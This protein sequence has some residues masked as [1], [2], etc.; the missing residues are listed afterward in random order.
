M[1][2]ASANETF[3]YSSLPLSFGSFAS[4]A[5]TIRVGLRSPSTEYP[6]IPLSVSDIRPLSLLQ[7][8]A[9]FALIS[10]GLA[11]VCVY[12]I[13]LGWYQWAVLSCCPV[14]IYRRKA[15]GPP[16]PY[17]RRAFKLALLFVTIVI[18]GSCVFNFAGSTHVMLAGRD[19]QATVLDLIGYLRTAVR[20]IPRA[21]DTVFISM[22]DGMRNG[23]VERLVSAS[24]TAS[25]AGSVSPDLNA[26][27]SGLTPVSSA[28]AAVAANATVAASHQAA[29][30]S[31]MALVQSQLASVVSMMSAMAG[32]MAIPSANGR[33]YALR[34]TRQFP[35]T[36][37]PGNASLASARL[38]AVPSISAAFALF[39]N[40]SSV[41]AYLSQSQS[42]T[43]NV[44]RTV[45]QLVSTVFTGYFDGCGDTVTRTK[46]DIVT[47]VLVYLI[48]AEETLDGYGRRMTAWFESVDTA[49]IYRHFFQGLVSTVVVGFFVVWW[50]EVPLHSARMIRSLAVPAT[51]V[52]AMVSIVTILSM[53]ATAFLGDTCNMAF[54]VKPPVLAKNLNVPII[55]DNIDN[56]IFLRDQCQSGQMLLDIGVR[57]GVVTADQVN[58]TAKILGRIPAFAAPPAMNM[59]ASLPLA[60]PPASFFASVTSF[61]S[62]ATLDTATLADLT[63]NVIPAIRSDLASVRSF[64]SSMASSGTTS[65]FL[66]SSGTT[67]A[68]KNRALADF[69]ARCNALVGVID[70]LSATAGPLD[71]LGSETDR[72]VLDLNGLA[73][74]TVNLQAR[75]AS[76]LVSYSGATATLRTYGSQ[77]A[78]NTTEYVRSRAME[79]ATAA[80]LAM[81]NSLKCTNLGSQTYLVQDQICGMFLSAADVVWLSFMIIAVFGALAIPLLMHGTRSLFFSRLDDERTF[82]YWRARPADYARLVAQ[83]GG[84][85]PTD[86]EAA[87]YVQRQRQSSYDPSLRGGVLPSS[88]ASGKSKLS[89]MT[90][91]NTLQ[92]PEHATLQM[93]VMDTPLSPSLPPI[94]EDRYGNLAPLPMP[95]SIIRSTQPYLQRQQSSSSYHSA[96]S[97]F[98]APSIHLIP[99]QQR[100]QHPQ[101]G[102]ESLASGTSYSSSVPSS[103]AERSTLSEPPEQHQG[104]R[105]YDYATYDDMRETNRRFAGS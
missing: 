33:L 27:V 98:H 52:F 28:A 77:L 45:D 14:R 93:N 6:V 1:Q 11:F 83:L 43:A 21:I 95:S 51:F 23:T 19:A 18:V 59:D 82:M 49:N 60:V 31:G 7:Y 69:V 104:F 74:L 79:S 84:R 63:A 2:Q 3:A 26:F 34:S 55:T 30:L 86:A 41:A 80:V 61:N 20:S 24:D 99:P 25:L 39:P 54:D 50:I 103:L 96:S 81:N 58:V 48:T 78:V 46:M 16:S 37:I 105:S 17:Q 101:R 89:G 85:Q 67:A 87:D 53:V 76:A 70:G 68:E 56:L 71:T 97:S 36:F 92:R 72:L 94:P 90:A 38:S 44:T 75:V 73:T 100:M 64:A 40:A 62:T 5:R 88:T 66:Y 29:L 10:I 15:L 22:F 42:M 9:P 4:I 8:Y 12:L 35:P 47:G 91:V 13:I 57:L 65:D 102:H 32:N